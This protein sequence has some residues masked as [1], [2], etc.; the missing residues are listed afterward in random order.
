MLFKLFLKR[1]FLLSVRF[2][3]Q[4]NVRNAF[5]FPLCIGQWWHGKHRWFWF[6]RRKDQNCFFQ[7]IH[8]YKKVWLQNAY[9]MWNY[10]VSS[11]LVLY[12]RVI[13][14]TQEP[15]ISNYT[16]TQI[17]NKPKV[18]IRPAIAPKAEDNRVQ[19]V[20]VVSSQPM[21][22]VSIICSSCLVYY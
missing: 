14:V 6:T 21:A 11:Y 10:I 12:F 4:F 1:K 20:R 17:N 2:K 13:R 8:N 3:L 22:Q 18:V 7:R 15:Q 5:K 19:Y 16:T 9:C